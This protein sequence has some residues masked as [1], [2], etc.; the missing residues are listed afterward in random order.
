MQVV[1]S[2]AYVADQASGLRVIDVGNPAAPSELGFL[3]TPYIAVGVEVVGSIA[4]VADFA[5][6]L[7]VDVSNPALPVQ[8]GSLAGGAADVEV[9]GS[10]AFVTGFIYGRLRVIDVS[11]PAFPVEVGGTELVWPHALEVEVV[12]QR[13]F[14]VSASSFPTVSTLQVFDLADPLRP[15][16]LGAISLGGGVP[17]EMQ[18]AGGVA[19]VPIGASLRLIDFGPE[20]WLHPSAVP[21]LPLAGIAAAT[22]LL[23][24]GGRRIL[25][26]GGA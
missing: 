3:E 13:A 11:N 2:I 4:Y 6:L 16:L 7:V 9:V 5:S 25:R 19:F 21:A 15:V 26:R 17:A 8:I 22:A 24:L 12:G 14:V 18:L 1:G 23:A 20:Y 10:L